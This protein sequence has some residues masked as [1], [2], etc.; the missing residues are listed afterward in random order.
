MAP[1]GD[2]SDRTSELLEAI[3]RKVVRD[4]AMDVTADNV[5]VTNGGV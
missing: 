1:Y 4:N 2:L 5:L 3:A